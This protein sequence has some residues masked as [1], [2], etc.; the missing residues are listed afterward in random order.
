M[1]LP[2]ISPG[3]PDK[4]FCDLL[5]VQY[6][7]L[8]TSLQAALVLPLKFVKRIKSYIK[9]IT[10]IVFRKLL[11]ELDALEAILIKILEMDKFNNGL[12][13]CDFCWIAWNCEAVLD[14][15]K[16]KAIFPSNA[17]DNFENFTNFVCNQNLQGLV[18]SFIDDRIQEIQDALD[19]I[20]ERALNALDLD[21][22]ITQYQ[23][24]LDTPIAGKTVFEWINELDKYVNC[25][26]AICD[27]ADTALN[28]KTDTLEK[29]ALQI[30]GNT[31]I[32]SL[33]LLTVGADN[34]DAQ[35]S[36]KITSMRNRLAEFA[37]LRGR[38]GEIATASKDQIAG[39]KDDTIARAKDLFS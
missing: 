32:V 16:T 29:L 4:M 17:F 37:T 11:T 1:A 31:V 28:L 8:T 33:D 15:L 27:Y 3:G 23:D 13:N 7:A 38:E 36:A 21:S 34:L 5:R 2:R 25:A 30:T 26:F 12:T 14:L 6:A 24:L 20:E 39:F 22:F 19:D 9:R 10:Q 18:S 35:V